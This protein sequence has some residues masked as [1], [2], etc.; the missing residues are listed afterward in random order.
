MR[1]GT[2][3]LADDGG[4]FSEIGAMDA[5]AVAVHVPVVQVQAVEIVLKKHLLSGDLNA[6]GR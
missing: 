2:P 3:A 6:P 5:A 1:E 4:L